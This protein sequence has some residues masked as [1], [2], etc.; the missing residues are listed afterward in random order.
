M[1]DLFGAA[2][3]SFRI[4][5]A[6][7]TWPCP[8]PNTP[9]RVITI[10]GGGSSGEYDTGGADGGASS[11]GAL[12]T[13]LGGKKGTYSGGSLAGGDGYTNGGANVGGGTAAAPGG[14]G[15][16]GIGNGGHGY[17]TYSGQNR[18][19]SG[20]G[21][22]FVARY[23]GLVSADQAVVVGAGGVGGDSKVGKGGH[24]AVLVWWKE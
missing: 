9:V 16:L 3:W 22:G 15:F 7:G 17:H 2:G 23:E 24:G 8:K 14:I 20:G 13:A 5:T 6:S 19:T 18:A 10:G 21:S 12:V 4:F 1:I 11:F